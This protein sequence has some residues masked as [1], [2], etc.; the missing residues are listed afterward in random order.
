MAERTDR[1]DEIAA[2]RADVEALRSLVDPYR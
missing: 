1:D 2:L